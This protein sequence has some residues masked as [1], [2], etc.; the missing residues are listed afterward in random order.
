VL[1]PDISRRRLRIELKAAGVR[2]QLFARKQVRG[3]SVRDDG[4]WLIDADLATAQLEELLRRPGVALEPP[5]AR[6]KPRVKSRAKAAAKATAKRPSKVRAPC[7]PGSA[8][9][10]SARTRRRANG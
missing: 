7:V 1:F 8:F 3:E 4:A 10:Q 5:P 9:L 6:K 2:S